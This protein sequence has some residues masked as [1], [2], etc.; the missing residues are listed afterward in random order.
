MNN[1]NKNHAGY[2][3]RPLLLA[4]SALLCSSTTHT[5]A[6]PVYS[7]YAGHSYPTELLFGETHLHSALS[8]DAGGG[9]TTLMPRDVYRFARGEQVTS[10]T[11]QA[12]KLAR[13]LDFIALTEHTDGM[14]AITDIISGTPNIMA[15]AQGKKFHEDFAAGGDRAKQASQELIKQFSQGTISKMLVYQP[16]NPGYTK[17]WKELVQAAE[18]FNEP[19]R[20]TTLIAYEWTS[21]VKGNNLHRNVIFRDGPQRALQMEPFTMT[22]PIGSPDPRELWKWLQA[23]ED[24]TGGKVMAIPHNGNLSNGMLFAM[25]NDFEQGAAF[26][27]NYVSTRQKWER[28]YEI[29]QTKGDTETHPKL[30]P[31]DEFADYETWDWGNLDL[32]AKKTPAMLP[33]E[34]ARTALKNGLL[35]ENQLGSNPFKFGFVGGSDIH[36]ALSTQDDNNFFG[37]FAWMEPNPTRVTLSAKENKQLGIGYKGWQYASPGPTAVWARS[38]TRAAIFDAMQRREVYA[39]TGPRI[40]VRVFGGYDFTLRDL[41]QH[42]IAAAGYARGVPMGGNLPPAP[43]EKAPRFIVSALRDPD[44]A[45]LDRVQIIKGW[46]DKSGKTHEK[47]YDVV[48]SGDRRRDARD[49]LPPVGDTVDLSVPTWSNTIGA[50]HLSAVW[51]DP[52]FDPAL[53]AFYYV[54]VIEIP[55]PRWTAYDRVKFKLDLPDDIPLKTQE[56]AYT[57]PIWYTPASSPST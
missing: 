4:L 10:N 13:P 27:E 3:H 31:D 37:A 34:Y 29:G 50:A 15:D 46:L 35:L 42:D 12:A 54:R 6:E 33:G 51:A 14:G 32:T 9:G 21:L 57:S 7:P 36:T 22:P 40:R 2:F 24:K 26:D 20:F 44:G 28:L 52:E 53:K 1:A 56:R 5:A 30:S 23:Y 47:V 25:Q 16:G 18:E 43:A 45:N 11:G 49:K 55:T 19:H 41:K 39:T 48:W 17:T 8:A 38:N